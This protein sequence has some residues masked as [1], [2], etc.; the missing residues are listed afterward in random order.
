MSRRTHHA[1]RLTVAG[2]SHQDLANQLSAYLQQQTNVLPDQNNLDG[3]AKVVF[4]FPGQ[5][6]QWLGMGRELF[7]QNPVFRAILTQCDEAIRKW[8]DWSLLEQL[9]LA[10]GSPDYRLNE[11]SVIQ[12]VLFAMEVALAGLAFLGSNLPR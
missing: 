5:G 6:A 9:M 8:A 4:V 2:K 11:I 12:T 3:Q 10:E 7:A 1:E